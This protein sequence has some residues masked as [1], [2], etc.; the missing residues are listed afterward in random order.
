MYGEYRYI[1]VLAGENSQEM[2]RVC[3]VTPDGWM[4]YSAIINP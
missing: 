3:S 2:T 1:E 4:L